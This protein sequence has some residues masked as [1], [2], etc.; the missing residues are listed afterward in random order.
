MTKKLPYD[1]VITVAYD[2]GNEDFNIAV[3]DLDIELTFWLV[4]DELEDVRDWS[5]EELQ[6]LRDNTPSYGCARVLDAAIK[7]AS[8]VDNN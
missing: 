3:K 2:D 5:V 8:I 4:D 1:T 7:R 6:E